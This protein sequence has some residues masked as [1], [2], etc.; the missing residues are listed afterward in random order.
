MD[1]LAQINN[2]VNIPTRIMYSS[3]LS[4][5]PLQEVLQSLQ[6][7]GL[8]EE[9]PIEKGDKRT[10]KAYRVSEKG[11]EVLRYFNKAVETMEKSA[12][13]IRGRV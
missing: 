13:A 6:S 2:G 12:K 10:K 9:Y 3:N 8:I 4:W 5:K 1:I 7:Q 11:N